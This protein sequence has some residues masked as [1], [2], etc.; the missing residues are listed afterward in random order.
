MCQWHKNETDEGVYLSKLYL[1]KPKTH[2][3]RT[4]FSSNIKQ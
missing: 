4:I 1:G 2:V 3:I